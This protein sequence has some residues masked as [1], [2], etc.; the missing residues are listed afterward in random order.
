MQPASGPKDHDGTH[1]S[2][3]PTTSQSPAWVPLFPSYSDHILGLSYFGGPHFSLL[4]SSP[5][6]PPAQNGDQIRSIIEG[7]QPGR[8][9]GWGVYG[10]GCVRLYDSSISVKAQ[11]HRP[12]SASLLQVVV[13]DPGIL[14]ARA[15]V[16]KQLT[17]VLTES[18][19]DQMK[20]EIGV[21]TYIYIYIC[22]YT[23][24]HMYICICIYQILFFSP[25]GMW[26][27]NPLT[28]CDSRVLRS[29]SEVGP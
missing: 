5:T 20:H 8:C 6:L 26:T 13:D 28:S 14:P 25:D 21:H 18:P 3:P 1:H 9:F 27:V 10:W 19:K 23:Y 15:L 4:S 29:D 2:P 12:F 7:H 22:I 11:P 16:V 17:G 24:I